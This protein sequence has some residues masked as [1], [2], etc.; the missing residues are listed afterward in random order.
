MADSSRPRYVPSKQR[1]KQQQRFHGAF[2]G[3]FSAGYFNTV[4]SKEGW[5]PREEKDEKEEV[6]DSTPHLPI[7]GND[8]LDETKTAATKKR[9]QQKVEDFMDEQDHDEWGGPTA[10]RQD[11]TSSGKTLNTA[12]DDND[13]GSTIEDWMK[14]SIEPPHHVAN[15]LL[16]VLGWR[17]GSST[18]YVPEK[19]GKAQKN[20]G[21]EEEE[22]AKV[23][24]SS[25]K[26]R[27]IQLQQRRVKIPPPKLDMCGL[28]YEPY[29]NAPEFKAYQERRRKLAQQR[30]KLG[31]SANIY[32]VNNV[33]ADD[34]IV[35][36]NETKQTN[37]E[38]SSKKQ[39]EDNNKNNNDD[40][41]VYV[42]YETVED[43]VGQ[44]SVGG[45]ALRDD[46]DDAFDDDPT[47]LQ[48]V[49]E[50]VHLDT[51]EYNDVVYEQSSDEDVNHIPV[52]GSVKR[53]TAP[54]SNPSGNF[55][56]AGV[57]ASFAET[58]SV[59]NDSAQN[60]TKTNVGVTADGRRPLSGFVL[61]G[62]SYKAQQRYPGPEVPLS[63][64]VKQH[65]FGPDE[66]PLVLKTLSRAVQLEAVDQ[67]RQQALDEA[68]K[69]NAT[70]NAPSNR[71]S[72][73]ERSRDTPEPTA[74]MAG[75]TFAG[76]AQAMKNRFT[77]VVE[78]NDD[79]PLQAGLRIPSREVKDQA[80]DNAVFGSPP[81]TGQ[82]SSRKADI[83]VTRTT[84]PFM[85][86]RLLCKR[87]HVPAPMGGMQNGAGAP[88]EDRTTEA[89]YFQHEILN[90][91]TSS[92]ISARNQNTAAVTK[93]RS[94][95]VRDLFDEDGALKTTEE[96]STTA[97]A[98]NRPSMQT[99]KSIYEPQS[100]DDEDS[101]SELEDVLPPSVE[102]KQRASSESLD[103]TTSESKL[104]EGRV[105]GNPNSD[106][107]KAI[108]ETSMVPYK[109]RDKKRTKKH[110]SKS[111]KR[112]RSRERK[113]LDRDE[114]EE[115]SFENKE[116]HERRPRK[117][118]KKRERSSSN[119]S[120]DLSR[121]SYTSHEHRKL[122]RRRDRD[123][124]EKK[125]KKEKRK[126]RSSSNRKKERKT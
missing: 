48:K 106:N 66:H 67:K 85:P 121:D 98:E 119:S 30:A 109:D 6:D 59:A 4:G 112:T 13:T 96:Q 69:A 105:D 50:K 114:N 110:H 33:L 9:P 40:D 111:R 61:G 56:L 36:G 122:R 72:F 45:F 43:F 93:N 2:S 52:G 25:K 97:Q 21:T 49:S 75:K 58:D 84:Y 123:R 76:L 70:S 89:S 22:E 86:H 91:A 51:E 80:S 27:K 117:A 15:R 78:G 71:L 104:I 100:E 57:L 8:F 92:A 23:V 35:S 124:K 14:V 116:G 11:Y 82:A 74:P 31:H 28:G 107:Y 16:R 47:S 108:K 68:L 64:Q 42:S 20:T 113:P 94:A 120:S 34:H 39:Q 103:E 3:G 44:K 63:Y 46:E 5:E 79:K 83:K 26:L 54:S 62:S 29:Q 53:H 1:R 7:N 115:I 73:A 41:N 38:I 90:P 88:G 18:A 10:I 55:G 101:T 87:F 125:Q 118:H 65:E 17:E 77:S 37:K 102:N 60:E 12:N 95:A 126:K 81:E 99:Y 32:R 19:E 24:L